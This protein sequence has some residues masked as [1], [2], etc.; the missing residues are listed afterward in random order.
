MPIQLQDLHVVDRDTFPYIFEH[1]A[2]VKLTRGDG[3]VRVNVYRPKTSDEVKVPVLVTY[4]PYGKDIP[5]ADFNAGSYAEVNPKHK[6]AHSGWE[7]PDPK[8]WTEHGYAV[9][10]AD[11]RGFGQSP[12]KADTMSRST[13]EAFFEVIEWAASQ[14]WSSGKVGLL[15]ISYYAGTQWRVAARNPKGLAAIIPWEGMSDYYRDRCRHGGILSDKF[16]DLWW[17]R[18]VVTNQYGRLGRTI[19]GNLPEEELVANRQD[20]TIDNVVNSFRDDEY[21]A[22]KDYNLS[23]IKVPLLSVGNWGGSLLH[24]RGNV[25]GYLHASSEF[26]YI[27]FITGRHDLP[28]YDEEV[29]VQLSFLDAF[30]KG[31]DR[32]G[33]SVKGKIPPVN[34]CIRKG[35]PGFNDA[36]AELAAFPRCTEAAWPLPGTQYTKFYLKKDRALSEDYHSETSAAKVSYE[37]TGAVAYTPMKIEMGDRFARPPTTGETSKSVQFTTKPFEEETELIGHVTAHL[38]VSVSVKPDQSTVPSEIDLFVT[39]RYIGPDGREIFYTGTAGDP[40]PLTKGWLRTSLRKVNDSHPQ[41]ASWNPYR[42]YLST[43]VQPVR[44]EEVYEVDV[45]VWPTC[46]AIEKGGKLVFEVAS[47]DTQG[48]GIFEHNHPEDRSPTKLAGLN[49]IHFGAGRS[50][51]VVLPIIRR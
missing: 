26:K 28:F 18:Q 3:L 38:N 45:E 35:D 1:N 8:F 2:D 41:H 16:I 36:P 32:V 19:E 22:S 33:W 50:N 44:P 40:V 48:C 34:L 14:P 25:Q 43:D 9:V 12:G 27:R 21:Y 39:L 4:G 23:D 24:L 7:M 17:N 49:H 10:R 30:L 47:A 20:Q 13:S 29:E 37:A 51:F 42:E 6:S 31:E 15:G 46:V 11:E 5:Y